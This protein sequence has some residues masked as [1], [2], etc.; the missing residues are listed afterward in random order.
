MGKAISHFAASSLS[1]RTQTQMLRILAPDPGEGGLEAQPPAT[2]AG[3][4]YRPFDKEQKES[5]QFIDDQA[6]CT[7][8]KC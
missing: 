7:R 2:H 4:H 8:M 6:Y 3:P 1:L 5:S